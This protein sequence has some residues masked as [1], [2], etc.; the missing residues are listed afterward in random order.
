MKELTSRERMIRT[1]RH[2]EVDRMMMFDYPWRGT[3]LRWKRE[4]M[5][6][7][8]DWRDYFGFDKVGSILPDHSI[9]NSVSLE[10]MKQISDLAHKLGQY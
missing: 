8:V 2:E 1:M 9:P 3:L 5:P 4:G 10:T 7:N 6:E